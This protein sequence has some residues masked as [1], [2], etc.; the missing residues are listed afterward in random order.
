MLFL[1]LEFVPKK[2]ILLSLK[3][4]KMFIFEIVYEDAHGRSSNCNGLVEYS[5]NY[6]SA[7]FEQEIMMCTILNFTRTKPTFIIEGFRT[8]NN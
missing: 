3:I 4:S 2:L 5:L 7:K 8:K 6:V 1:F